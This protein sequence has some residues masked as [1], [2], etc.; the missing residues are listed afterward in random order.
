MEIIYEDDFLV[1]INKN[2]GI[3]VAPDKSGDTS[4]LDIVS[5][6][7]NTGLYILNRLDRPVSGVVLFAKTKEA[8]SAVSLLL[9]HK[10]IRKIY[11]AAV[12]EKPVPAS[13]V[14]TAML[15]KRN[16]KAYITAD[17]TQG[18][19]AV[20]TY[21]YIFS[22]DH[23]HFLKIELQTGRFHQIRSQLAGMNCPVKGDVKYGAKRSNKDRSIHL[24]AYTLKFIHPFSKQPLDIRANLPKDPVWKVL[25]LTLH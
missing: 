16:N 20:L 17:D 22:S 18:K 3:P 9:Q 23:Y 15:S 25:D 10:K 5:E 6:K 4:C 24:H 7:C 2:P 1:A 8:A 13:G 14:L 21:S 19:K 12:E 11:Y